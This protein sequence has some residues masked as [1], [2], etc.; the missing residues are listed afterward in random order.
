MKLI[1][2]QNSIDI[3]PNALAQVTA[4]IEHKH[5][6]LSSGSGTGSPYRYR[7][8]QA[9]AA[10]R[11]QSY[12]KLRED[13]IGSS[14]MDYLTRALEGSPRKMTAVR[15]L[16]DSPTK[17]SSRRHTD[18]S[19]QKMKITRRQSAAVVGSSSHHTATNLLAKQRASFDN[20]YKYK[21]PRSSFDT[22]RPMAGSVTGPEPRV[23]FDD[24]AGRGGL[25]RSSLET[26]VLRGLRSRSSLETN[27]GPRL[28]RST[29]GLAFDESDKENQDPKEMF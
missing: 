13:T 12:L 10:A 24:K 16:A 28:Q 22:I 25:P 11:R 3:P 21:F 2:V 1:A 4:S 19:P 23:S 9:F 6:H 29:S 20:G 5:R 8:G 15:E 18:M 7:P 27:A 14:E 17:K 26:K